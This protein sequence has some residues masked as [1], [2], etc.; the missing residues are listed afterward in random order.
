MQARYQYGRLDLRERK[1]G[2]TYGSG[3]GTTRTERE[4]PFSSEQSK[5]FPTKRQRSGL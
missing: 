1:K 5:V 4:S 3:V 2:R